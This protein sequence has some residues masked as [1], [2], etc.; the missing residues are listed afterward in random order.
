MTRSPIDPAPV[1]QTAAYGLIATLL[2]VAIACILSA[3]LATSARAELVTVQS[4]AGPITVS[5]RFAP[6]IVPLIAE[7]RAAGFRGIVKC[8]AARRGPHVKH[9]LHLTG[10]ACD[11]LPR[12][13]ARRGR[14]RMP[15]EP[16]MYS[17][18]AARFIASA[19]LRNGCSFRDC[20]H[21]DLG[22]GASRHHHHRTRIARQ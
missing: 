11:F 3:L 15:T 17:P 22:L 1:Y 7:L 5:D 2:A 14:N 10:D 9:S 13:H 20:G 4:A 16:I 18:T 12:G 21:V 8:Y 6:H 19:G